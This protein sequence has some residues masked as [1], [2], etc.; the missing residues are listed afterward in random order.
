MTSTLNLNAYIS[1]KLAIIS[2]LF[3]A[4]FEKNV[5]EIVKFANAAMMSMIHFL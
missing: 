4:P 1:Q 5:M 2:K 3:Y